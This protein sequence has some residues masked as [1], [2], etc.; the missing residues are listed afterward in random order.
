MEKYRDLL[1][2]LLPLHE[3]RIEETLKESGVD[4]KEFFDFVQF[5]KDRS[6]TINRENHI[7]WKDHPETLAWLDTTKF[8]NDCEKIQSVV[9]E[10]IKTVEPKATNIMT[11]PLLST[12]HWLNDDPIPKKC[13]QLASK[14]S[15]SAEYLYKCWLI[16]YKGD[17]TQDNLNKARPFITN[18]DGLKRLEEELKEFKK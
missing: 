17:R 1:K 15:L 9:I 7:V 2:S 6:D 13:E 14:H 5:K 8:I 18:K 4:L 11:G 12:I 3:I 10:M 16:V